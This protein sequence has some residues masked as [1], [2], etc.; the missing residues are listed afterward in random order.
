MYVFCRYY[1][2]IP[3]YIK[4]VSEMEAYEEF[5]KQT[6]NQIQMQKARPTLISH[7]FWFSFFVL[8]LF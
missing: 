8:I 1:E 6:M 2:E 4:T 5:L 3:S 7:H